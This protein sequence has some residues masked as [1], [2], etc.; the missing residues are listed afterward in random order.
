MTSRSLSASNAVV[1]LFVV[2]LFLS[3]SLMFV[4][5]PMVAKTVLPILG[6]TPMVWNTCVLFFQ[7]MLLG[8]YAYAHGVTKY[9][10]SRGSIAAYVVL[11]IVPLAIRPFAIGPDTMAPVGGNPVGWLLL[12]LT[13]SIGFPFFV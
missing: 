12:P 7:V 9:L 8:G 1:W 10:G 5:E 6:G 2:T 11:L 3:A 4:I 13:R